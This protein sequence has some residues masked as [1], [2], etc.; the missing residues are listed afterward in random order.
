MQAVVGAMHFAQ[1]PTITSAQPARRPAPAWQLPGYTACRRS[2]RQQRRGRPGGAAV[3]AAA[4]AGIEAVGGMRPEIDGAI[5]QALSQ[6]L[7]DT[8]LGMGKKYK[9]RA[10]GQGCSE[11]VR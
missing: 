2:V 8:D 11:V 4:A 7:T 3:V 5:Q 10:K 6:C 9:V 1:A